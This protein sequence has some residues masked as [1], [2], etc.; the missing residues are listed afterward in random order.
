MEIPPE[1]ER[2]LEL[3]LMERKDETDLKSR[4]KTESITDLEWTVSAA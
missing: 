4:K 3:V 2:R 1:K